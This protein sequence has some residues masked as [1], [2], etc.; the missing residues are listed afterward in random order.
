MRITIITVTLNLF[1]EKRIDYFKQNLESVH[2]QTYHDIEHIIIDGGSNDGTLELIKE[3]AEQGWITYISEPDSGIYDAMNKGIKKASG[4]YIAF[5]NSDD[6]YS[7]NNVIEKCMKLIISKKLDFCAGNAYFINEKNSSNNYIKYANF[8]IVFNKMP[9]CHQALICK[10]KVL[11]REKL[12]NLKYKISADYD[13]IIKLFL[14]KYKG[15]VI[16]ENIVTFRMGG[17]SF[18]NHVQ[19]KNEIK[20]I[21][22]SLL[23]K[24][25]KFSETELENRINYNILPLRAKEKLKKFIQNE[26]NYPLVSIITVCYNLIKSDRKKSFIQCINSIKKQVYPNIEHIIIDGG[27]LDGTVELIKKIKLKNTKYISEKDEGIYD[28]MRKGVSL[29]QGDYLYF[30]NTDDYFHDKNVIYDVINLFECR[31]SD[32]IFGNIKPYIKD[33]QQE[34]LPIFK[35]NQVAKFDDITSPQ[36]LLAR[37]IHHQT[38]FYSKKIFENSSF[39]SQEIE[40]GSD[41]LLHCEAFIKNKYTIQYIDRII[42]NFNLGG[43]ST[44][45]AQAKERCNKLKKYM[46]ENFSQYCKTSQN[47]LKAQPENKRQ[48]RNLI[49]QWYSKFLLRKQKN[50]NS[51]LTY[52]F[53]YIP[54]ITIYK[55]KEL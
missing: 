54:I 24:Y 16:P 14:H 20:E 32:A 21:L 31:R 33:K 55:D 35:L 25:Y 29:A 28:A 40:K 42:T 47:F 12:F 53:F 3:Y 8:S 46:N 7:R 27:S 11:E 45:N 49:T 10:K 18:K 22:S 44:S 37:N 15:K 43:V 13:F 23:F 36:S 5:L 1:Q 19:N 38:I 2:N 17:I 52:Y 6:F 34:Y 48:N 30:L 4:E 26:R 9:F 39:F 51:K 50:K 41:W